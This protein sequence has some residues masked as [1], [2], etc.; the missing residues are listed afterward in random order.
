[1]QVFTSPGTFTTPST[2]T[3]VKLTVQAGGGASPAPGTQGAGAGGLSIG[4]FPVTAS[5]PYPITVGAAGVTPGAGG[6]SSFGA[7][8]SA[9]GG[10][11]SGTGGTGTGGSLNIQSPGTGP[12]PS[13]NVQ[14]TPQ[15]TGVSL[16]G[17][18][19]FGLGG[20][21]AGN[22]KLGS[23]SSQAGVVIVEY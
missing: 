12:S 15:S 17:A 10:A 9:T 3:V 14:G 1:M 13:I 4:V 20:Y 11:T 7:L 22:S 16:G 8:I 19:I 23:L 6:S 5:T 21:G 18:T 2:T